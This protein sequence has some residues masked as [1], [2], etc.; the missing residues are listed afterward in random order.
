[1]TATESAP[2]NAVV[3]EPAAPAPKPPTNGEAEA[4]KTVEKAPESPRRA[5]ASGFSWLPKKRTV[6]K[7]RMD[8]LTAGRKALLCVDSVSV[9]FDGFKALDN[10]TL[11]LDEGELRCIIG[12]NGA[13][14]TTL[15]DVIT[16]KTKPDTGSV[17]LIG[18][19]QDLTQLREDEIAQRG[20]CR[21]FQR[22][23]V[24]Q[25]HSVFENLELTLPG[26]KRV[27][28][29][30]FARLTRTEREKIERVLETHKETE[31]TAELL[32][33]LAGDHTVVVVEHDMEFV[34]SIAKTVT[35]LHEGRV[36]AEGS[37]DAVQADPRVIEVYL[38]SSEE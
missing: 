24:F 5:R 11:V 27:F 36:L 25:G 23:T 2:L 34:R 26:K 10:L 1:M 38:G 32:N 19:D 16:G 35:V 29:S 7:A 4:K 13:G 9:S 17:F 8:E 18:D 14:K 3:E 15:Q 33:S 6:D 37:M 20:V 21:K 12:P 22:P 28:S 31:K 30:L